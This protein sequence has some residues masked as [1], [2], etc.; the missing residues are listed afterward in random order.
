MAPWRQC[1]RRRSGSFSVSIASAGWSIT[2]NPQVS[3]SITMRK[4]STTSASSTAGSMATTTSHTTSERRESTTGRSRLQALNTLGI[5][6][7]VVPEIER[8]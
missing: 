1:I 4:C 2:T 6:A 7:V 3:A 8:S 5:D